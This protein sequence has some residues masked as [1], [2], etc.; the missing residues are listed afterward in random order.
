MSKILP[1]A[2]GTGSSTRS[3]IT[4]RNSTAPR[5]NSRRIISRRCARRTNGSRTGRSTSASGIFDSPR[6]TARPMPFEDGSF[7][8]AVRDAASLPRRSIE[9]IKDFRQLARRLSPRPPLLRGQRAGRATAR[10]ARHGEGVRPGAR[11]WFPMFNPRPTSVTTRA[12]ISRRF[13]GVRLVSDVAWVSRC[14]R[15]RQT[16]RSEE[17]KAES[18]TLE[19]TSTDRA[20]DG[21]EGGR[22]DIAFSDDVP[23][24]LRWPNPR[25][26]DDVEVENEDEIR[27]AGR[28][29]A[30]RDGR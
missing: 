27:R 28:A 16:P 24:R 12:P 17:V 11:A 25:P 1:P 29:L 23:S 4:G 8:A 30:S 13:S 3:S 20:R 18:A 6:R 19:A 10:S 21:D 2:S 14:S 5:W 7:D 9:D 26:P 22:T 15:T